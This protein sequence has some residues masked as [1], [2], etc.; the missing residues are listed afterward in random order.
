MTTSPPAAG[1]Q[2]PPARVMPRVQ[3]APDPRL[4]ALSLLDEAAHRLRAA[5]AGTL[6]IYYASTLPFVL[7]A[8][9]FWADMSRSA[10]AA[11]REVA[12]SLGLAVLFVAMKTGQAVFVARL[13]ASFAGRGAPGW[14]AGR[15]ARVALVQA[16]WQP[17][18]LFL[19]P[20]AA[21]LVFPLGW[22]YA[23]YQSLTACGDG[24]PSGVHPA[25][26]A[27]RQALARPAQNHRALAVFW[28]LEFCAWLAF[29][30]AMF[31]VPLFLK[32]V[33]GE[34]NAFT[35]TD[36]QALLN[37][38]FLAVSAALVY[39]AF[40]PLAKTFYALRCFYADA[41]ATGED[42]LAE[43][44]ALPPVG[45]E[46]STAPAKTRHATAT[47]LALAAGCLL[48]FSPAARA[49]AP[50]AASP[51]PAA[52]RANDA[53]REVPPAEMDRAVRDVLARREFAWRG[54][55]GETPPDQGL[56][57][58]A[59]FFQRIGETLDR[60]MTALG[61]WFNRNPDKPPATHPVQT[62]GGGPLLTGFVSTVLLCV[63]V[64]AVV[65]AGVFLVRNW[66][67]RGSDRALA[68]QELPASAALPDLADE[69][70]LADQLPEDEWLVLA[71]GLLA[72]GERR[73]ALRAFYLSALSGL[74]GRGLLGIARHKSNRDYQGE[75][76]RRARDRGTLQDAF[77]RLVGRFERVW[78]GT[79]PADD[80][81]LAAFQDDRDRLAAELSAPA[82]AVAAV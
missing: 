70:V 26:R 52:A 6:A 73:L 19:L 55:R 20:L 29:M 35:R 33:T 50:P 38:T 7:A 45:R 78:Y 48:V 31:A 5:S 37:S 77:A 22:T 25:V 2:T 42:L 58:V 47:A 18:G 21:L 59:R 4:S 46:E 30:V 75:L 14:T 72:R 67:A 1:Q 61:R 3:S 65:V 11:G 13:R 62:G 39:L 9:F 34:D 57:A 82:P 49:D 80:A 17:T 36:W 66:R 81:L 53:A 23:F 10:D 76:R 28:G 64:A 16:T 8:L 68:G 79:H 12:L 27:G 40:N 32:T 63:L 54:P 24:A 69:T 41:Q 56:G 43:L 60:W 74:G 15:L 71:R 51:A 44:R